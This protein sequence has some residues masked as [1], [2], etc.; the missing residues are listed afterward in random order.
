MDISDLN[1]EEPIA[2]VDDFL[3]Q[4]AIKYKLPGLLLSSIMLAR[5][6]WLNKQCD[7]TEDFKRLLISVTEGIDNK[8]FEVPNQG[9]MH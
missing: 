4:L 1:L 2:E 5:L 8:E 7:S 3:L 6:M 9:D